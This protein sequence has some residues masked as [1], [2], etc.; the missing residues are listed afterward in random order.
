MRFSV[1]YEFDISASDSVRHYMPKNRKLWQITESHETEYGEI[2]PHGKHRKVCAWLTKEQFKRWL[3]DSILHVEECET[4]GSLGAP[5]FGFGWSPAIA[6][7][8]DVPDAIASAYVT[9]VPTKHDGSPIRA[10]GVKNRDWKRIQRA[11]FNY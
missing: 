9:P 1:I 6:Y 7:T 3:E 5:G 11:M 4:M 8:S 2:F 10:N